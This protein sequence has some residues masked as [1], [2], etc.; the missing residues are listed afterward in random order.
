MFRS[1][2]P[3][4][5]GSKDRLIERICS[6]YGLTD[7]NG[8]AWEIGISSG[9]CISKKVFIIA[10]RLFTSLTYSQFAI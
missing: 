6:A 7:L 2:R 4:Q 5:R 1:Q 8:G 3:S 10:S 9:E